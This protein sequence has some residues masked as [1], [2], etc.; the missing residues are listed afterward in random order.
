[1]TKKFST[2]VW[3]HSQRLDAIAVHPEDFS[4]VTAGHDKFVVKWRKQKVL[5]KV[6][7]QTECVCV[8]YHP[9]GSAVAAGTLD[10]HAV[11]LNAESGA[12]ITTISVCGAP[13]NALAY[14]KEG[15]ILAL[16]MLLLHL[17]VSFRCKTL[18]FPC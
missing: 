8:A 18:L 3:G 5:W 6:S 7:V 16:G 11:I 9:S 2:V 17:I 10:G 1:M 13:I 12:H 15:D 14:N 4:F